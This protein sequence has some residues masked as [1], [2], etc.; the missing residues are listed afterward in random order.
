MKPMLGFRY[1]NKTYHIKLL[2]N[3]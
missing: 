2:L 1:L 3:R